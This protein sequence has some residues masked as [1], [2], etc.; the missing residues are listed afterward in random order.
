M[1]NN[2][3]GHFAS[4]F[5]FIM[6]AAGSA[7]GLGNVWGF[8]TQ[9]A[10][11]GG[12]AFL[13]IYLAM[14]CLLAF[15]MLV[16]E[17]TIGRYGQANAVASLRS[18]WTGHRAAAGFF[19]GIAMLA[20]SMI[21]SFYSILGGWLIGFA[22]APIFDFVGLHHI[23]S[24]L[25]QTGGMRNA[26]LVV[27]FSLMTIWVVQK[28]VTDGIEKWSSRLMPALFILFGVMIAY[29]LTQE[30][31]MDGVIMYLWPDFSHLSPSLFVDA[32]GQ[33]FFSLSLG[34]G[35]MMV[36]GSYI[37]KDINIPKTA[38]QVT[39]IGTS[40]AFAAGLLVLPA[41]FVAKHN[42]VEIFDQNGQLINS[43]DLVFTVLP[44]MFDT[45]GSVGIVVGMGFFILMVIAALTSTISMLEV[46]VSYAQDEM[47]VD[48][49]K[50]TW[51]IGGTILL[52]SVLISFYFDELFDVVATI[53]TVYMQPLLGMVW[54]IVVGWVWHRNSVLKELKSGYPEIEAG[55]FWKIWPWYV[56]FVC[57]IAILA[58]F[59]F[60]FV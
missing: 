23:A 36:Y 43:G 15:P 40:V 21:L 58:V 33:A 4:K 2:Q 45:M 38:A 31:A 6:A 48:R 55:L 52:T 16:A 47:K 26:V 50:A 12:A 7:V 46:P 44:A 25:E 57:P 3:R 11:N 1:A 37:T 22:I 18:I 51:W 28:G 34:V 30:G 8:P 41:M 10:S 54:A 14:T 27:L 35:T 29:I 49:S 39:I 13:I 32:M 53:S 17:L 60:P 24:W 20:S 59:L 5:G 9:T 42:G 56:R 19:G